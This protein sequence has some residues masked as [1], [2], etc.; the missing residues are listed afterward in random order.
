MNLYKT[1]LFLFLC[2][3]SYAQS[4]FDTLQ[5]NDIRV[6]ASHNSYK[7]KPHPKALKFLKK[8]ENKLGEE[9]NPDFIDYGHL[10]FPQQFSEYN[11]RGL[12]LDVS[13]DPKGKHYR[14]RRINLFIWGQKQ[15]IRTQ[16][17][18]E[19]GFKLLHIADVDFETN[20]LTFIDALRDVKKWSSENPNHVPIFINIEAKGSHLGDESRTLR[21]LGFKKC[22]PFDS[23]AYVLLQQ[24]IL[25][26]FSEEDIFKPG[27]L[28]QNY[29]SIKDRLF[30]EG[31]PTVH[32][33]L[34]KVVFILE[35][36]NQQIYRKF[37]NPLLFY[38][39]EPDDPNTAFLIRNNPKGKEDEISRY[40]QNY[41]VRTRCDALTLESRNCDYSTWNA[42]IKSNAQIISTDYYRKD[43]RWSSYEVG[44]NKEFE[45]VKDN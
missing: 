2:S 25:S 6:I 3:G 42:A 22:I 18:K 20:Y 35:G 23:T 11:V 45:I 15:R 13:Y 36:N 38:Y 4:L 41:I 40:T 24:E 28:K 14:R 19:P 8:F 44:F 16:S 33:C 9:N 34:G 31:W 30:N 26:V 12:E 32:T 27:D 37:L 10:P 21:F 7:K 29:A 1:I 17:M 43:P 39:G 5:L